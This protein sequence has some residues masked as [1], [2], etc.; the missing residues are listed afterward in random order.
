MIPSRATHLIHDGI[1]FT[2]GVPRILERGRESVRSQRKATA[3][4]SGRL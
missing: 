2:E 1:L 3:I 4:R